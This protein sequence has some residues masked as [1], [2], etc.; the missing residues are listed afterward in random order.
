MSA[1]ALL[2]SRWSRAGPSHAKF[3]DVPTIDP[4]IGYNKSN[5]S[6]LLK[7]FFREW[8]KWWRGFRRRAADNFLSLD[9]IA[10]VC[11]WRANLS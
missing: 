9:D 4:V 2:L 11:L 7:T 5:M 8:T 3:G 1:R 6:A 10:S